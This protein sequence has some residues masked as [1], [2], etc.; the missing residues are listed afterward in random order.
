[1]LYLIKTGTYTLQRGN[2]KL[3]RVVIKYQKSYVQKVLK[4]MYIMFHKMRKITTTCNITKELKLK[5]EN[6]DHISLCQPKRHS[7][8]VE[9]LDN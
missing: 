2:Y 5:L 4:T 7:Y 3:N 9:L 8:N 1:M 6:K